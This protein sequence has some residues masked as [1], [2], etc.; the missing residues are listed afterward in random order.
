MNISII[1]LLFI[2]FFIFTI[3]PILQYRYLEFQRFSLIKQLEQKRK[4]RVIVLIHRQEVFSFLGL[5]FSRFIDIED[6]ESILRA[7]RLTPV[8]TP[9]DMI[10]HTPGGLVLASEQIAKALIKHQAKVTI[11]IP[12]YAMSGGSLIAFAG[13]EIVMDENAVLSPLDP[14]I[15]E[16]PAVSL[17]NVLKQKPMKNIDDK[18]LVLADVAKKGLKQVCE[19]IVD[20]LVGNNMKKERAVEIANLLSSGQWTHDYP[21]DYE[22]AKRI[23]LPVQVGLPGEIYQLMELYPQSSGR[24]PSV[25]YIPVPYSPEPERRKQ[26]AN[27]K[28]L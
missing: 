21:I 26:T 15:G 17:L 24:R 13:D 22:I 12:H 16:Y 18:T 9:I 3:V 20:I 28:G 8:D 5:P 27:D 2:L 7:I 25:Q 11:F 10:V 4:S 19:A 14:Q 6:S 1:D 23:G